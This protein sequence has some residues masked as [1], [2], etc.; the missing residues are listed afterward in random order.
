[1]FGDNKSVVTSAT[2]PTSTLSKRHHIA[3][4]HKVREAIAAKYIEFI[5]KY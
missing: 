1:M 2:I 4:Y 5:W 3:A